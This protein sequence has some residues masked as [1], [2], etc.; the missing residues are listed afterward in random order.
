MTSPTWNRL[1]PDV[2]AQLA[3]D[4]ARC[5]FC[6]MHAARQGH[7]PGCRRRG[8]CRAALCACSGYLPEPGRS[9]EHDQC[10]LCRHS[11]QD[12]RPENSQ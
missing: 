3:T 7:T 8:R 11:E 12:H 4:P 5:P 2:R 9:P 10:A 6:H 1:D